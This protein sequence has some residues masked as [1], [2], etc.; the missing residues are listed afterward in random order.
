MKIDGQA[1]LD[2]RLRLFSLA[3][4]PNG[5]PQKLAAFLDALTKERDDAARSNAQGKH[6]DGIISRI[7]SG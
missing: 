4:P 6:A 5:S 1:A 7:A 3:T 2:A